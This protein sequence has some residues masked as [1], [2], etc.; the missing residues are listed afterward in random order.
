M[1]KKEA[2]IAQVISKEE[3]ELERIHDIELAL[4]QRAA[5]IVGDAMLA[6][7]ID[8][9]QINFPEHWLNSMP[10]ERAERAFATAK[11]AWESQK[12][13]PVFLKLAPAFLVGSMKVR[14]HE[15]SGPKVL[16]ATVVQVTAPLPQFPERIVK[17]EDDE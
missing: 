3:Q 2:P 13:A 4:H 14:A 6:P 10:R 16:N 1:G 12:E 17:G 11:A 9:N 7:E 5:E 15:N 8:R